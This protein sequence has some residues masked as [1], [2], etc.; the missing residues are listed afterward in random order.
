[1]DPGVDTD[2]IR[3][4]LLDRQEV[5]ILGSEATLEWRG[6]ADLFEVSAPVFGWNEPAG[7]AISSYGWVFNDR[8]TGL[9]DHL[10]M[11]DVLS[12]SG[13]REYSDEF[14]QFDHSVGW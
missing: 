8:S 7:E 2:V 14:R 3:H 6:D 9:F 11:P 1:M 13:P 10:R 5:R 12:L 4:Q